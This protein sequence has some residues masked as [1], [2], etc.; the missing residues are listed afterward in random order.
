MLISK[1][2]SANTPVT[3]NLAGFQPGAAAQVWQLTAANAINR[4]ADVAVSGS[5]LG[6]SL[7]PQSVTLVVVGAG[8]NALRT[9]TGLRI[10]R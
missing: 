1:Y 6:L 10:T 4:Q 8:S 9:P 7:P 2:L 5:S 3:V